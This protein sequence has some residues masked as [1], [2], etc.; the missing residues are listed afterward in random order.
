VRR[1]R[2]TAL[3]PFAARTASALLI[4][5]ALATA[6]TARAETSASVT[7]ASDYRY[8]GESLSDQRP[9]VSLDV[10]ADFANGVYLGASALGVWPA[11]AG[12]RALSLQEYAGYAHRLG[13][14]LTADVGVSNANYTEAYAGRASTSDQELYVGLSGH[15]VT[16]RVF[17][18][19][20]YFGQGYSTVY[21]EL[22]GVMRPRPSW[23]LSGQLGVLSR[24]GGGDAHDRVHL[25]WRLAVA[26]EIKALT[27]ETAVIGTEGDDEDRERPHQNTTV[28][29]A[30]SW[31]F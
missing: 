28:V 22:S 5:T 12:F 3:R 20:N 23:R 30:L 16:G 9:V 15:G 11:H 17:Y 19:P 26:K 14:E 10:A 25:D 6:T 4:L 21:G 29:V 27:L 8:R 7:V 13:P 31:A 1:S 24:T 18:S 2:K